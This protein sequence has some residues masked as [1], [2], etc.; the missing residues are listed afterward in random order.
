[1][2]GIERAWAECLAHMAAAGRE[3]AQPLIGTCAGREVLGRGAG[4][5]R[6]LEIDRAPEDAICRVLAEDAPAP[7]RLVSEE[8]GFVGDTSAPWVI[9]IDPLDGSLN[10][11][12][13]L[14]PFC[15]SL[16]AAD[17]DTIGDVRVAHV[18]DYT[19]G[20]VFRAVRG[21]GLLSNQ[22]DP[23]RFADRRVEMMFLEAGRPDRH[24]FAYRQLISI[25][26]GEA[27]ADMRVRQIGS[28]ALSL[29]YVAMG[30]GD[31]L[32]AAVGARSV[33]L[34]AGLLILR[35]TGGGAVGFDGQDL[36]GQPLDL[37]RR[38]PFV[39]WRKGLD[40]SEIAG[41]AMSL[42]RCASI[43]CD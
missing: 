19:R 42:Q 2:N 32:V 14:E 38:Q 43:D 36:C 39:A 29:C 16:A 33:D 31:L 4:G 28:L 20:H 15:A 18:E 7:Y 40:G 17:G 25:S 6:T 22:P 9:V 13:G 8:A 34:A 3:A 12:R 26:S 41:R 23:A 37:D 10:A 27:T 5:D 30:V 35:E 1:M 11:K 21:E 24:R